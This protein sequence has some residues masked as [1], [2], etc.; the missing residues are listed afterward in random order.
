VPR[1][2]IELVRRM[3]AKEPLRRPQTSRELIEELIALEIATFSQ[4][5]C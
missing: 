5:P 1:E 4:R 3:M 2:V